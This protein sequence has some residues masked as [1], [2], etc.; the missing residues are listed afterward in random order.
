MV[1]SVEKNV[2]T[3]QYDIIIIGGGSAGCVLPNRLSARS[4]NRVLLLEAGRDTAPG[5][6]P[7]DI[8]DTYP[9]SYYNLSY[10]WAG[11]RGHWRGAGSPNVLLRQARVLGGGARL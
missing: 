4:A 11:L 7:A 3:E 9:V 8:L 6:E 5:A 2:M 10:A 1:W